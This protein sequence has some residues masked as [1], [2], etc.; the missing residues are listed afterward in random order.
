MAIS[1]S[2]IFFFKHKTAYEL[3]ISDWSS[4]V[5][6]SDLA[7]DRGGGGHGLHFPDPG[8]PD[9][10]PVREPAQEGEPQEWCPGALTRP[11]A[12]RNIRPG[13]M[14]G[15]PPQRGRWLEGPPWS[16]GRPN[17]ST[18]AAPARPQHPSIGGLDG[19]PGRRYRAPV[20]HYRSPRLSGGG[21]G[22]GRTPR[23]RAHQ[24]PL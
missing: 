13:P 14:A 7:A 10:A 16:G 2:A 24:G 1:S 17:R 9:V 22:G 11:A 19:Q 8:P 5:C 21:G 18:R 6:S 3:R 12:P 4:D 20:G 15:T 23:R